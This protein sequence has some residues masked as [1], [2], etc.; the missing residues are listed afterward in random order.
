MT[1]CKVIKPLHCLHTLHT[2]RVS[3]PPTRLKI[4]TLVLTQ[5]EINSPSSRVRSGRRGKSIHLA[6]VWWVVVA[7]ALYRKLRTT[8]QNKVNN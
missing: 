7:I 6:F 2:T 5:Y 1:S 3:I 4:I 8:T